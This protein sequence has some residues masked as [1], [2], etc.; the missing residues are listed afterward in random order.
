MN[1]QRPVPLADLPRAA[2]HAVRGVLTDIDDTLTCDGAV[3]PE[4]LAALAELRA[5]GLPVIAVTGRPMGW[6]EPYA[7]DWPIEAIVTA[8][9][10]PL[11]LRMMSRD[12]GW[13][14]YCGLISQLSMVPRF[15]EITHNELDPTALHFINA[16]RA[17]LPKASPQSIYWGYMFLLGAMIQAMVPTGRIDR[18]S[19]GLCRSDDVES[20]LREMVP[21]VCAGLR[22]IAK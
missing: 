11:L 4:A 3:A 12:A 7:R 20:G 13:R 9:L 22:A 6:S 8:F 14:H 10:E 1:P 18:L 19:R 21:F 15:V 16:L 2:A 17:A 5:A